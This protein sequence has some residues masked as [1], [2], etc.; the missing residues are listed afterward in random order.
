MTINEDWLN[1]ETGKYKCPECDKEY[2]KKGIST[3]IIRAHGDPDIFKNSSSK[4]VKR[5][6]EEKKECYICSKKFA[7]KFFNSH[8]LKC[9]KKYSVNRLCKICNEEITLNFGSGDFCSKKCSSKFSTI[10]N[11]GRIKKVKCNECNVLYD[12]GITSSS[13]LCKDCK[14]KRTEELECKNCN[15]KF[16]YKL[17]HGKRK[18]KYCSNKCKNEYLLEFR[19]NQGF[20]LSKNI[21]KRSK[22][23]IALFNLC[24]QLDYCITHNEPVIEG[25]GWDADIIIRDIKVAILWN[26]PWHYREMNI[27]NHSLKQVKNRDRIKTKLF[28]ENGWKVYV[29]EDRDYTPET[30]FIEV[31]KY[32]TEM[33]Q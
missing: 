25:Y 15:T 20:E 26:G 21:V 2:T 16:D 17:K 24:E 8:I 29:F 14:E 32:L 7:L 19:R 5:G 3:H 22:D 33:I 18:K 28:E 9:S 12:T 27:G 31:N 6:K 1:E 30:A 23:E 13:C 11:K 10:N 4:G